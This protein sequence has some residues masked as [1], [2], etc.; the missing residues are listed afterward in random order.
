MKITGAL[1]MAGP[2]RSWPILAE[3]LKMVGE[4]GE[5]GE[6]GGVGL[7]WRLLAIY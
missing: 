2:G 5:V 6:V 3:V 4:V 7:N 1:K